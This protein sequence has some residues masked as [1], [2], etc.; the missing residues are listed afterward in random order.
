MKS[1]NKFLKIW[2]IAL[3]IVIQGIVFQLQSLTDKAFLG[4]LGTKYI[5]ALG[6][7]QF[8]YNTTMDAVVALGTGLVIYIAQFVGANKKDKINDYV[9]SSVFYGSFISTA[10]FLTWL[11]FAEPILGLLNVDAGILGESARYIKICSGSLLLLGIDS[12]LQSRLQ[13]IG[14]TK[15]IMICGVMKVI[16]NIL[17]SYILIFGVFGLPAMNIIGAAIGTLAAN[18][19]SS[20]TLIFYCLVVKR[21][22]Y[23]LLK[24]M[25]ACFKFSFYKAVVKIGI[26][27]ALEYFLWNASNLVLIAF[28]NSL[29]FKATAVYTL[30]FGIECVIFAMFNGVGKSAMTLIGQDVGA[31]NYKSAG[32]YM[33]IGILI[34][35]FLVI[36]SIAAFTFTGNGILGIF[37][38]DRSLIE[39]TLPF[40]A[41]TAVI[42]FP[43]SMNVII[44]NSIRAYGNT[45]WMLY[46]Q[47]IG[48]VFV[49]TCS[50]FLVKVADLGIMAIYITL[51]A[52]ETLRAS[53]N[54]LYYKKKYSLHA[55]HPA[56]SQLS[57]VL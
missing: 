54:G 37:T 7:A 38:T 55:K 3:P 52:D 15:P 23:H 45:K 43:K 8:P 2:A 9:L 25:S 20:L 33:K 56:K 53:I 13:G 39:L 34:N 46:S 44:G 14:S 49:V 19:I 6:A 4:N 51:F 22:E 16:L 12:A 17:F 47:M 10:L 42:M 32:S 11:F 24:N 57:D 50:F 40:L 48:S 29:S 41:F 18:L 36:L 28:L 5:S 1:A 21:K 27:T 35:T 26:P 31:K 30:T